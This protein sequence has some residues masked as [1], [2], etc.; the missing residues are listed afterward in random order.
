M[1]AIFACKV[2]LHLAVVP[3][4]AVVFATEPLRQQSRKPWP[5]L[6][7]RGRKMVEREQVCTSA[8]LCLSNQEVSRAWWSPNGKGNTCM[9]KFD[10]KVD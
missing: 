10:F 9:R 6:R 5:K 7:S 1:R 3:H 4:N 8:Q 2:C